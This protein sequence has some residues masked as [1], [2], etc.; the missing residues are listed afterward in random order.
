[1]D[2]IGCAGAV[3]GAQRFELPIAAGD[4]VNAA[5]AIRQNR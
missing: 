3:V 4:Y 2:A 5:L 1:M